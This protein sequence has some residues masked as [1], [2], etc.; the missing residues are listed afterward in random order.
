MEIDPRN[1]EGRQ[2][3]SILTSL[4]VPRPIGWVSTVA[5]DG[6]LN[7]APHSYFNA[8][9]SDPPIVHFTS[10][11]V[12]DTFRNAVATG[13]FVVNVVTHDLTDKMNL[14]AAKMPPGEN[15]FHWAGLTPVPSTM[16]APPRVGEA[17]AAM[18]C[19]VK[20]TLEMGNG[21]MV[22]GEV[23]LFHIDESI[24]KDG[25]IDPDS[26]HALGR[27][28]GSAYATTAD[29]FRLDR[30]KWEDGSIKES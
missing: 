18:E 14:T 4:V 25:A 5:V 15:E 8:V 13:E 7:L 9:S 17:K 10:T 24:W 11:G 6:V 16:I 30:P 26:L 3:Y 20:H 28:G 21:H 27:L 19:K 1:L 12:K 23:V 2:G 29:V 22:F